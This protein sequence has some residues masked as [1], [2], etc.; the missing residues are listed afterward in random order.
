MAMTDEI[1]S[2]ILR[3]A[4]SHEIRAVATRQGMRN[5]REDGWRIVAEGR[6]TIEEVIRNTKDEEAAAFAMSAASASQMGVSPSSN[7]AID[8]AE[9][10]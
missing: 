6:T 1:R 4:A 3:R 7:T 2:L 8:A 5:L 10:P 9:V